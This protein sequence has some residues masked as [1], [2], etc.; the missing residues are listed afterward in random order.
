MNKW[1]VMFLVVCASLFVINSVPQLK[2]V[3][4]QA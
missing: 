1:L 4:K 3:L 2:Q